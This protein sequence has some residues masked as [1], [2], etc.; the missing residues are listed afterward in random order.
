MR[1]AY[2]GEPR[3]ETCIRDG[4]GGGFAGKFRLEPRRGR[5]FAWSWLA[6]PPAVIVAAPSSRLPRAGGVGI[7]GGNVL[8]KEIGPCRLKVDR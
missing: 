8:P 3:V 7:Q 2:E 4:C 6:P 1:G 5:A